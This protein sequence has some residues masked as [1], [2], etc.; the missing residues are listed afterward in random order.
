MNTKT[1][2]FR[3]TVLLSVV[4]LLVA[5]AIGVIENQMQKSATDFEYLQR[6]S[7]ISTILILIVFGILCFV[8]Y[9]IQNNSDTLTSESHR[10]LERETQ[11]VG[12]MSD[13][14][15][16]V[17]SGNYS[18][19]LNRIGDDDNL[20]D[21][22]I[23]M[24]NK[25]KEN[26][27]EDSKRNWS[28]SGLAQ[29]GDILRTNTASVSDLYDNIIRFV[30]KYTQSNQ[31]GLFLLNDDEENDRHLEL[32]ACYAFERKKFL[33]KKVGIGEGLV[34]QCF[35]EGEK[36]VMLKVPEDYV[37]ITSGLG[38]ANPNCLVLI[39]MKVNEKIYGVIEIASFKKYQPHEIEL[40]EKFA[41]SIA[42]TI[43]TVRTNESTKI[44]LEKSQQQAEEMKAQ[45]EEMR[46]NMEELSAT[47]EEM[48]RKNVEVEKM[49]AESSR[50]EAELKIK[51]EEVAK[52]KKQEET[53]NQER[54]Q[55]MDNYKKTLVGI[56]DHLPHK[57]FLKDQDG[58]MVIVNTAV[59]NA[60]HMSIDELIGKSDFDFVDE[61]TA[62][63]WRKQELEIIR[64]GSATYVHSDSIGGELRKLKT[65]KSAFFIP[66]LNQTGLLGVQ[67]DITD[68]E[69]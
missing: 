43:S 9:R 17:S 25:L 56:L 47:Q 50:Q 37:S 33:T 65:V 40:V 62:Q 10:Q 27:E 55:F 34:G 13:F 42:S 5:V 20:T 7:W 63:E 60:H 16:A 35:L 48:G 53:R 68:L 44:L 29:I 12:A 38:G 58:K 66:H 2:A 30:V 67:T 24:R 61:A 11:R 14:I 8:L 22:L 32:V 1:K 46:Q 19:E 3:Y 15:D 49:L 57:I 4:G 39:P 28:T 26:A 21:K 51:L 36:I 59:A 18:V 54:I 41:E 23:A 64:K 31:G 69:K 45:E 6:L 52:M